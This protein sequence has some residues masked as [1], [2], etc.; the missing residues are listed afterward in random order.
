MISV[1]RYEVSFK[2]QWDAFVDSAKNG[3]FMFRR[4][5]IDYHADRFADHSLCIFRD[6]ELL[7]LMPGCAR[8]G[9][10]SSHAGLTFGGFITGERMRTPVM[11][12]VLDAVSAYL[13]EQNF[14]SMLYKAIPHIYHR[15][16]A[17]EDT[18]ALVRVGAKLSRCDVSVAVSRANPQSYSERRTR[19]M[20]K[21]QKAGV[22][23]AR[24]EDFDTYFAIVAGLLQ[25]KYQSRPTHT[26]EE[27]RLLAGRFPD[28][29]ALWVAEKDG[30]MLAG[31]IM[32]VSAQVAHAQYIAASE[33]GKEC[34]ALDGLFNHLMTQAYPQQ[35]Y[36]DFGISTEQAGKHL[37]TGLIM[38]KEEFGARAV[39]H[40]FFSLDL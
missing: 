14:K 10:F 1:R 34:G 3:Q 13:R 5:Y 35:A 6:E 22:T 8:D 40:E 15:I 36:F 38:Q 31:V 24:S 11:L 25:D 26:S 37:N 20:K 27:M 16:P 4:D 21:A 18:Y 39:V 12:E 17:Q 9:E 33:Q 7:A 30:E 28:N 2:P 32:Y 29:I 19:G 23:F